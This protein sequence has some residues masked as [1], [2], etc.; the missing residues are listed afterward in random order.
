MNTLGPFWI[1]PF[2]TESP[3]PDVELALRDPDGLLAVGGNLSPQR[4]LEA[5]RNAIFPWYTEGQPILWWAP[6]PRAV[7]FPEQ[8]KV[9]RSLRK[10]VR[11]GLFRITL[12]HA[13]EAVIHGC[14]GPRQ[15]ADGTWI[16]TDMQYAYSLL[17]QQGHAHSVEAW[18]DDQLV[19]GLYGVALGRVFFGESMFSRVP[20]ASKV[21]FVHLVRQLQCWGFGVIDCQMHTPHLARFG[22]V[23]IPRRQF[24]KMLRTH[25]DQPTPDSPWRFDTELPARLLSDGGRPG[26]GEGQ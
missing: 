12:D 8:L 18:R 1:D 5:Y 14:A 15:D 21:A 25:C 9:S 23:D 19:G 2:D 4:L 16:T 20:D 6:D 11:K 13:F 10:T 26:R 3:F 24:L 22:A 17:H 7:L